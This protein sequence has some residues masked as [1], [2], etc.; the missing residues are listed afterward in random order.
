MNATVHADNVIEHATCVHPR[1][2][3]E[4]LRPGA[5]HYAR[6]ICVDCGRQVCWVPH[7]RNVER[8]QRNAIN[9]EKLLRSNQLT[10][11][12]RGFCEGT[13]GN[14][15]SPRQQAVLNQLV[16]KYLEGEIKNDDR[17]RNGDL[18]QQVAA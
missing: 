4:L 11:W 12:E 15:I 7:R 2:R 1:T 3:L 10:D 8:R 18:R 14:R 5:A 13:R 16:Q 6:T 9:L 17:K